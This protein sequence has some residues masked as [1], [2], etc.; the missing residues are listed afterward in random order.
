MFLQAAEGMLLSLR[1]IPNWLKHW[2]G[3]KTVQS[4]TPSRDI[5]NCVSKRNVLN[6]SSCLFQGEESQD[7]VFPHI[8]SLATVQKRIWDSLGYRKQSVERAHLH[9][10][11]YLGVR[12]GTTWER[13]VLF[14][15]VFFGFF[16]PFYTLGKYTHSW[17]NFFMYIHCSLKR[18]RFLRLFNCITI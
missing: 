15:F 9:V 2:P 8:W 16:L 4:S 6:P 18:L 10:N 14:W 7:K 1:A 5:Q 13:F 3:E 11:I 12:K 17:M